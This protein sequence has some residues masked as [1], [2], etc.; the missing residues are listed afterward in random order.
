LL[1]SRGCWV[2]SPTLRQSLFLSFVHFS[3]DFLTQ[4]SATCIV[5]VCYVFL[6]SGVKKSSVIS[7]YNSNYRSG[8]QSDPSGN[9]QL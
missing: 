4:L 5:P 8:S 3:F 1:P 7:L 9:S 2:W 6:H